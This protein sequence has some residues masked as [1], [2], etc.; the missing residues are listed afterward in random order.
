M[1]T[2][3]TIAIRA[4]SPVVRLALS[5]LEARGLLVN[6]VDA[7]FSANN[8]AAWVLGLDGCFDFHFYFSVLEYL[9]GAYRLSR[10][11]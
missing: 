9:A 4:I 11:P 1:F 3:A 6:H 8:F 7:P 10:F 5:R 2:P